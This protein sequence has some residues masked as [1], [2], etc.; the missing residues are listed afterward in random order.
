MTPV[1]EAVAVLARYPTLSTSIDATDLPALL[2][3]ARALADWATR[4]L[5]G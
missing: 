2:A 5:D 3:D 4:L 1:D